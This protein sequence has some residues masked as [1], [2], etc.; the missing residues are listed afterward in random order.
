[1]CGICIHRRICPFI[2]L[3]GLLKSDAEERI[4]THSAP[5]KVEIK[6]EEFKE[7]EF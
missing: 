4:E 3:Q 7:E 5:F 2:P 1:M 6:C